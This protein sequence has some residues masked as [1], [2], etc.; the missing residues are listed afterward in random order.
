MNSK[1]LC[2]TCHVRQNT[3]EVNTLCLLG[4]KMDDRTKLLLPQHVC[5]V[6]QTVLSICKSVSPVLK[7]EHR[8]NKPSLKLTKL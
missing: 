5:E 6:K 3:Y 8:Y 4:Q 7:S 2:G 1:M